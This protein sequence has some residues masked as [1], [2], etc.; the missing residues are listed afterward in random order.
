MSTLLAI[1]FV[2]FFLRVD[3]LLV[4]KVVVFWAKWLVD[5]DDF[6][7]VFFVIPLLLVHLMSDLRNDFLVV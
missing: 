2:F 4:Q 3:Q 7:Y 5:F 1:E 6:L